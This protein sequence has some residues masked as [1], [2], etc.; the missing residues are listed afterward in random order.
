MARFQTTTLIARPPDEVFAFITDPA[1]TP[2]WAPAVLESRSE[3]PI[4]LG[5]RG[6]EVRRFMGRKLELAWE[7]TQY[8]PGRGYGYRYPGGP[9][10]L[11]TAFA[12]EPDPRGTR[13]ICTTD[14]RPRGLLKL[15]T[16]LILREAKRED[17]ENFRR[18]KQAIESGPAQGPATG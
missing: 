14:L 8:E 12:L 7:I 18:L 2:V 5:G 15:L 13:L 1:N 9:I 3:G 10:P 6:T 4:R 17:A 16:P 11:E